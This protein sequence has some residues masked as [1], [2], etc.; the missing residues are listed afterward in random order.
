MDTGLHGTVTDVANQRKAS[1]QLRD[2]RGDLL[3]W[4]A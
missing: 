2:Y 1:Y 4:D 3:V